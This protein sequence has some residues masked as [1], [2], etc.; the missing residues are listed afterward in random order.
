MG[1]TWPILYTTTSNNWIWDLAEITQNLGKLCNRKVSKSKQA[2]LDD[3]NFMH[4]IIDETFKYLFSLFG[5]GLA[6]KYSHANSRTITL[7]FISA[8]MLL[9][10]ALLTK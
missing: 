10:N 9:Q 1:L 6:S 7:P 5:Q 4:S 3:N 2:R 8:S